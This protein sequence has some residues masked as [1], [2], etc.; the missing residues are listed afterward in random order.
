M[1]FLNKKLTLKRK[2]S[3]IGFLFISPFLIGFIAFFAY[4]FIQAIIFSLSELNITH[5]GYD[6]IYSGL[7]NYHHALFVDADFNRTLVESVSTTFAHI[8]AVIIFSFFIANILNQDFKG[9]LFARLVFFLPLILTSGVIIELEQQNVLYEELVE[10]AEF[11]LGGGTAIRMVF[12]QLRMPPGF[13]EYIFSIVDQIP[14]I[15]EE[16]AIPILIFLAGLQSIPNSLYESA[17]IDGATGWEKFWKITWPLLTPLFLVNAVYIVVISLTSVRNPLVNF[18]QDQA[19]GAAGYGV[20]VAMS[21]I[22]FVAVIIML[23]IVI[24]VISRNV[25]YMD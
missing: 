19:W 13:L 25:H 18:I 8:P 5:Q 3:I 12:Q 2:K 7:E 22:Y 15:L 17:N 24:A 1:N 10:E 11:M 14:Q 6:L 9:R 20:S 4:P 21:M 16:S 23:G